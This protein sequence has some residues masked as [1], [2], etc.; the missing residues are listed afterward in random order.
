MTTTPEII[1]TGEWTSPGAIALDQ[2]FSKADAMDHKLSD[3]VMNMLGMSGR[4]YRTLINRLI[5]NTPNARYLEVGSW[6]GS[7]SCAAM[8]NNK[9]VVKCIDNWYEGIATRDAFL[10]NIELAKTPNVDFSFIHDNFE[11]VDYSSIG[12]FNVYMFDGPHEKLDQYNGVKLAL[13][14][15]DDIY[16]LVVDDYNDQQV[17]EG[18]TEALAELNQTILASFTIL[19][20]SNPYLSGSD[21]HN[22][23]FIAVVKQG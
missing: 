12:K 18:T 9:V 20:H 2:A 13:P 6:K 3:N 21:W 10:A 5:E 17:Q 19:S 22:G 16:T 4:K 14:A 11:N 8:Y 1:K 15:L 23:Y 7:T